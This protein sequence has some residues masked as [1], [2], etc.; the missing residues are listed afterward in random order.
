MLRLVFGG[1]AI[2]EG[3]STR[4]ALEENGEGEAVR[5]GTAARALPG[6]PASA[7]PG[8]TALWRNAS[9]LPASARASSAASRRLHGIGP[10]SCDGRSLRPNSR[11]GRGRRGRAPVER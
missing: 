7:K 10:V 4:A 9:R 11:G 8:I 2:V 1:E 6:R 5:R 3:A